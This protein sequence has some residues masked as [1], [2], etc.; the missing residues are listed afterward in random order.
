MTQNATIPKKKLS[1]STGARKDRRRWK[2]EEK[3]Q[4]ASGLYSAEDI[5]AAV[6]AARKETKR[7]CRKEHKLRKARER[8]ARN[9]N[10]T[11]DQ[12]SGSAMRASENEEGQEM[13]SR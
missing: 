2:E 10:A 8:A 13:G 9:G 6:N 4:I 11:I 1:Y 12:Q 3:R 5:P 7:K